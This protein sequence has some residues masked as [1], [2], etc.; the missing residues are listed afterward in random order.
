MDRFDLEQYMLDFGGITDDLKLIRDNIEENNSKL[1][2]EA[3]VNVINGVIGLY[4]MKFDRVWR[5]F[6]E[7]CSQLDYK[8]KSYVESNPIGNASDVNSGASV[9]SLKTPKKARAGKS[10]SIVDDSHDDGC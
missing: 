1:D 9:K 4:E 7:I 8:A 2:N 3:I 6:E 5:C 10:L